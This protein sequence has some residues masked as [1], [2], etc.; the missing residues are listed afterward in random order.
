MNR[1]ENPAQVAND[2]YNS[3]EAVSVRA[4]VPPPSPPS[5]DE[6][7][8]VVSAL[9]ETAINHNPDAAG[10]NNWLTRLNDGE[11]IAQ[12]ANEIYSS[13]KPGARRVNP[14]VRLR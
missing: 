9:Y 2:I 5:H 8:A 4:N 10:L 11:N 12:V 1:G 3:K 6:Q 13:L 7:V 14:K